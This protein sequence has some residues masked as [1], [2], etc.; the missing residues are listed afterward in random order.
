M[1]PRQRRLLT[2]FVAIGIPCVA[3]Q[4]VHQVDSSRRLR[5]LDRA[6]QAVHEAHAQVDRVGAADPEGGAAANAEEAVREAWSAWEEAFAVRAS[7][8]PEWLRIA[9][10]AGLFVA[11]WGLLGI[12]LRN[13]RPRGASVTTT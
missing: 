3:V 4:T 6:S 12:V 10:A 11:F 8:V 2:V 7:F 1:E 9:T 13:R 5:A